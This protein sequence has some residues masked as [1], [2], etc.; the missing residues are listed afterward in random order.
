MIDHLVAMVAIG[1]GVMGFVAVG[2]ALVDLV[3]GV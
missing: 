1:L 3:T 2:S